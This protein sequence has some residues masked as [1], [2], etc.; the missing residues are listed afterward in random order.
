MKFLKV[1]T[2]LTCSALVIACSS[3]STT[4]GTTS[5]SPNFEFP[6]PNDQTNDNWVRPVMLTFDIAG[7]NDED[8]EIAII[9]PFVE[10]GEFTVT[11][12]VD[13]PGDPHTVHM[14]FSTDN[15]ISDSDIH[16]N[17]FSCIFSGDLCAN[18]IHHHDIECS[19]DTS[20]VIS[21]NGAEG[22][23]ISTK[24]TALPFEG[25]IVAQACDVSGLNCDAPH[26]HGV[27]IR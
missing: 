21:C 12:S 2:L 19:F 6:D 1:A 7:Q 22:E 26:F 14:Y 18:T 3:D 9:D 20:N 10:S 17:Q 5:D 25:F 15:D 24:L 8:S 11:Y 23:D 27:E 13:E 16:F 4:E